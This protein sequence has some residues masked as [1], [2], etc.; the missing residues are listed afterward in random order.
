MCFG[1]QKIRK[2]L[3]EFNGDN[4]CTAIQKP[5]SDRTD[6]KRTPEFVGQIQAMINNDPS[7]SVSFIARDMGVSFFS[8]R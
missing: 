4:E 7:K 1:V 6:K 3:D 2:E 8:G 5:Q